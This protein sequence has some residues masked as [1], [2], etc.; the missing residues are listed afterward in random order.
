[1]SA[2]LRAVLDEPAVPRLPRLLNDVRRGNILIPDFQR[3]FEWD[4]ERRLMLL[5]S[6]WRGLPIGSLMVWVTET[7]HLEELHTLDGFTV[8]EEKV[9]DRRT[10][11]LDGHQRVVTLLTALFE[12]QGDVEDP[13][14]R[15]PVYFDLQEGVERPFVIES[16]RQRPTAFWLPLHL[17]LRPKELFGF[18]KV[19]LAQ[20]EER[21]SDRAEEV[22]NAFKDYQVPV[23]PLSSENLRLVTDTFVR[24]NNQGKRMGEADM[25]RALLMGAEKREAFDEAVRSLEDPRWVDMPT[26]WVIATLKARF[27]LPNYSTPLEMLRGRMDDAGYQVVLDELKESL[28]AAVEVLRTCDIY[29]WRALPYAFQLVAIAEAGRRVGRQALLDE[30]HL[31]QKWL[32]FTTWTGH[33][34]GTTS[35]RLADDIAHLAYMVDQRCWSSPGDLDRVVKRHWRFR[36]DTVRTKASVW[37]AA[38]ILPSEIRRAVFERI[39]EAGFDVAGILFPELPSSDPGNRVVLPSAEPLREWRTAVRAGDMAR[40]M[41]FA[42]TYLTLAPSLDVRLSLDP[43]DLVRR[44]AAAIEEMEKGSVMAWGLEWESDGPLPRTGSR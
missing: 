13:K 27:G 20:G 1:M 37:M 25:F 3:L 18:Q 11:L 32:L 28:S 40:C 6:V 22:A 38:G 44:R 14:L 21:A 17:V 31:I 12:R 26:D 30:G 2:N 35:R 5:D 36:V 34:T 41:T 19:L 33:F 43:V 39:A 8:G 9:T 10:Y 7:H 29:G 16:R 15:W 42:E 23:V 4:D 24:V